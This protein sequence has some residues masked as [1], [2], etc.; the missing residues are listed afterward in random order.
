[1]SRGPSGRDRAKR[2]AH[3]NRETAFQWRRG[4]EPSF[5]GGDP[6][7]LSR[8]HCYLGAKG[9]PYANPATV[10]EFTLN[11][12]SGVAKMQQAGFRRRTFPCTCGSDARREP[13][14]S[15]RQRCDRRVRR[16]HGGRGRR[17]GRHRADHG[18]GRRGF[19][20]YRYCANAGDTTTPGSI[21]EYPIG[22]NKALTLIGSVPRGGGTF[23]IATAYVGG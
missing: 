8:L 23:A 20:V 12:K 9:S 17:A 14:V 18:P 3:P 16:G 6:F 15:R 4:R 2:C 10:R 11:G 5:P 19:G 22:A 13:A 1:M 21:S 7:D